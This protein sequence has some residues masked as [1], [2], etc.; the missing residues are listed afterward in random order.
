VSSEVLAGLLADVDAERAEL[1]AFLQ[2]QPESAWA[3][4]TPAE[5]WDVRDQIA[6]LAHFDSMTRLSITEPEEFVA[7][8]DSLPDLQVYVDGIGDLHRDR[9]GRELLEWWEVENARL[10]RAAAAADPK[11][12]VPWFGPSMSLASKLTARL[13]ETWAHGQDVLDAL[14]GTRQPT[15][16]LR[17]IARIGVLAFPNSYRTRG[18]DVPDA[19]VFVSLTAPCDEGVWEWGDPAAGSGVSG[20]AEDFCLVVTQRRHVDDTSLA[21]QGEVAREWMEIAQAFAGDPG[22]GRKPGQF[23]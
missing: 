4:P 20:P 17:H 14:G 3:T 2:E 23:V 18:L 12:R 21:T 13:M 1:V 15:E 7:F 16:R 22:A 9:T 5:G 6:H 11:A 8:R 10:R 19:Q